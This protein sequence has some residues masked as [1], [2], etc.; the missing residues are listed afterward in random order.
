MKIGIDIRPTQVDKQRFRGIGSYARNLL[1]ALSEADKENEYYLY[2][3]R[4]LP[5]DFEIDA[6]NFHIE[7]T[8]V[9]NRLIGR[10]YYI[11]RQLATPIDMRRR[12]YDI[13][14]FLFSQD[15]PLY[16]QGEYIVTVHDLISLI[17]SEDY[18][19]NVFRP[20]YDSIWLRSA[21][22]ATRVIAVSETTKRDLIEKAGFD[23]DSI[24]VVYEGVA[25][26]FFSPPVSA[27]ADELAELAG[28]P[29]E[30]LFY[31]GGL[32]KR[33]NLCTLFKALALLPAETRKAYPLVIAGEPDVWFNRT[34]REIDEAGISDSVIFT[35]FLSIDELVV[36]YRK[37]RA[38]ILPSL[39]EGFGLP[40][41]EAMA[42]HTPVICAAAGSLPEIAGRAALFFDPKKPE[43]L[44]EALER[45][46]TDNE[47]AEKMGAEG[48][49]HAKR[50]T[51]SKTAEQ[52]IEIYAKYG[53]RS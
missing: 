49:E 36:A 40:I 19:H 3:D 6:D 29:P 22:K 30:Y 10:N 45:M 18:K 44:A 16:S 26:E 39:Y 15:A 28:L 35:G 13:F 7:G 41:L 46:I 24:S 37:A 33:K 20:Y 4:Y 2:C 32:D 9:S 1:R 52:T 50:F 38:F 5:L 51:W 27:K 47:L 12:G 8:T 21:K 48:H 42:S 31:L 25:P 34:R 53:V 14:H 23:A 43:E 17:F 11:Q